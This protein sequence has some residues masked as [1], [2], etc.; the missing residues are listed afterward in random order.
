[1]VGW[2]C[3]DGSVRVVLLVRWWHLRLVSAVVLLCVSCAIFAIVFLLCDSGAVAVFRLCVG[4]AV[5]V[6]WTGHK[7]TV[8]MLFSRRKPVGYAAS[9]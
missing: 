8:A 3:K 1:M 6:C 9:G 5:V 4:G 2:C 7:Q